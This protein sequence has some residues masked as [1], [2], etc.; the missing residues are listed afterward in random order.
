[1]TCV[2]KLG[3]P[4]ILK[5]DKCGKVFHRRSLLNRHHRQVHLKENRYEC[6]SC[7]VKF[8]TVDKLRRHAQ[9]Q[10]HI[11]NTNEG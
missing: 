9:S 1:M 4:T 8:P 3:E 5:C 7:D 6:L 2:H 10:R 11:N